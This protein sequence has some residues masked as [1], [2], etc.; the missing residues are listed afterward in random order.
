MMHT[1][2]IVMKRK[3]QREKRLLDAEVKIDALVSLLVSKGLITE[4][5]LPE[6]Q[7]L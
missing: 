1:D 4:A 6:R 2:L 7:R 5:E 3:L